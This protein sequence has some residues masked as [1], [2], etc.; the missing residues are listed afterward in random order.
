MV[1]A[2]A[3]FLAKQG[4]EVQIMASRVD[5]VFPID[6]GVEIVSTGYK[7]KLGT[8]WQAFAHRF[9]ADLIIADIIPMAILLFVKNGRKVVYFAQDY[10]ESYY[11]LWPQKFFIRLLYLLGLT[12]FQI[13]TVAVSHHLAHLL[14][15]RFRAD[16]SVVT[17]GV[18]TSVFYPDHDPELLNKKAQAKAIL[19]LSRS[20]KRKG[21]DV[22]Q[23]VLLRLAEDETT[24]YVVWSV[25][26][27]CEGLLPVGEH[28]H[29]G[30]VGEKQLRK[31]LSCADLFLYP[32][33]HEGFPLMALESLAC[34]C[35]LVTTEAVNIVQDGVEAL[36][37]KVE[38]VD[39]LVLD[40]KQVLSDAE[41][42]KRLKQSGFEFV[43][44]NTLLS[45]KKNFY[46][47]LHKL[48]E[49]D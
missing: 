30:Y 48:G 4:C 23:Q 2:Y 15:S 24:Q 5:T 16:L 17:N 26:E 38:D 33:R 21:F 36:I 49:T 20:D 43:K 41:L 7:K 22:A 42:A 6:E 35:P 28:Y 10:D 47:V 25:G 46:Q 18:D 3:G 19:V 14:R 40:V 31:I 13:P 39:S 1:L 12:L 11:F 29:F 32:S 45:A 34:G 9:Q 44:N 8:L 27:P 37:S